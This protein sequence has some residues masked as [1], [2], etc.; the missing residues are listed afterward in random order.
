MTKALSW[1][2]NYQPSKAVWLGSCAGTVV[3][4][5]M[6]GF[7]LGGWATPAAMDE[8]VEQARAE[9]A[10]T[11]CMN[12]FLGAPDAAKQLSALKDE[13]PWRQDDFIRKGT[14]AKFDN[15]DKPISGAVSLCADKLSDATLPIA[16][17]QA[18]NA[19]KEGETAVVR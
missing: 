2:R 19:V 16:A 17:K 10:A 15:I 3:L 8:Q 4:T 12:R 13:A 6:L 18:S 5:I 11:I 14:W 1:W 9:L 7:N